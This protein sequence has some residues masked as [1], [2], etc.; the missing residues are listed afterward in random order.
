MLRLVQEVRGIGDN[1][2]ER[3]TCVQR[4]A[5]E[6]Q[7]LSPAEQWAFLDCLLADA[8]AGQGREAV[9]AFFLFP[10]AQG[11]LYYCAGRSLHSL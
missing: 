11:I 8:L 6:R 7:A 4:T 2:P 10:A 9:L 1:L 5:H 3:S